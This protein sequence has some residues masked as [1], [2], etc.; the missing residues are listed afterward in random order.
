M[1]TFRAWMTED[2]GNENEND[3]R[4]EG[5][6]LSNVEPSRTWSLDE[7]GSEAEAAF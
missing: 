3:K 5:G 6:S 4:R 2:V 1:E 7:T